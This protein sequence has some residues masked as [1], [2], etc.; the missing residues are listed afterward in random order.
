MCSDYA[1]QN[2]SRSIFYIPPTFGTYIMYGTIT[3]SEFKTTDEQCNWWCWF[4]KWLRWLFNI[5]FPV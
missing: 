5:T 3:V 2:T 1:I 4:I